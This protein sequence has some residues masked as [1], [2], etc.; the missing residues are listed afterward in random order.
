MTIY[1]KKTPP[2]M[3]KPITFKEELTMKIF[4]YFIIGTIYLPILMVMI[5]ITYIS[6]LGMELIDGYNF[7][8]RFNNNLKKSES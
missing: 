8:K 4:L 6:N 3:E 7:W 5:L 2:I 1:A